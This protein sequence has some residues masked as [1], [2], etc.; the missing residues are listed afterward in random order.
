[1]EA[2]EKLCAAA[3][4]PLTL[5]GVVG[6]PDLVVTNGLESLSWSIPELYETWYSSIEDAM[7]SR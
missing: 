6:G 2:V 7:S 1:L 4:V 5:L 3:D